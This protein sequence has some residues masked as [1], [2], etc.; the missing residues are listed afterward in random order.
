[1]QERSNIEAI[2]KEIADEKKTSP[3]KEASSELEFEIGKAPSEETPKPK[4]AP[5]PQK[6]EAPKEEKKTESE[7]ELEL[8][9]IFDIAEA[10]DSKTV[11]DDIFKVNTVYIPRFTGVSDHFYRYGFIPENEPATE[12][13]VKHEVPSAEEPIDAT[14]ELDGDI[15][16]EAKL[17]DV[18]E[19]KDLIDESVS[20]VFKFEDDTH[21]PSEPRREEKPVPEP[22]VTPEPQAEELREEAEIPAA[23]EESSEPAAISI[24]EPL[25]KQLPEK[26]VPRNV[27]KVEKFVSIGD[28]IAEETKR[29]YSAE[30]KRDSFKD[31]FLDSL[32]SKKLRFFVALAISLAVLVFESLGAFGVDLI[33]LFNFEAKPHGLAVIDLECVSCIVLFAFP[34]IV[35]ALKRAFNKS[36][37]SDL[38]IIPAYF[39]YLIYSI[40]IMVKAPSSYPLFGA[41]IA[42]YSLSLIAS[43]YFKASAD[44]T[45]F[46]RISR[47]EDKFVVDNKFTRTLEKENMELDGLVEEYKSRTA[48]VFRTSFVADFFRRASFESETLFHVLL[49]LSASL[50]ASVLTAF[51]TYF[52]YDGILSAVTS[53]ALVFLFALPVF[54][55]FVH[56]LPHLHA[57]L[58][59]EEDNGTLI[60][61]SSYFDY[62]GV[63]VIC[64]NDTDVFDSE[65]VNIQRIMLYG[66]KENLTKALHQMS[67]LFMNVGGPLDAIFQES[68]DRKCAPANGVTVTES[69]IIGEIDGNKV[70]AGS[71]DFMR[72]EGVIVPPDD[73]G[74]RKSFDATKIM[75]AAENGVVYAKFYIRYRFSEEFTM[76][77]P[78]FK[79]E[80][81]IPLV[82]TRDP[83]LSNELMKTLTAGMGT[84]RI[85]KK[86]TTPMKDFAPS[87]I[88]AGMVFDGDRSNL[89]NLILLSKRYVKFNSHM[90]AL[91]RYSM[92][93]GLVLG[94]VL[95]LCGMASVIP[96]FV[97][98]LWQGAWCA[99]LTVLSRKFFKVHKKKKENK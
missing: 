84:I 68:L 79:E 50:G 93:A 32:M 39:V 98:L 87:K 95:S 85:L 61:E 60:G 41:L 57:T 6:Q 56:K 12:E 81:I 27:S 22:T 51:I 55:L 64:I 31:G 65:D 72:S 74:A 62:S 77:M 24:E 83:N 67:A 76:L 35:R 97:P 78:I 46:K 17:V 7:V 1:M 28:E 11:S 23:K 58:K 48:R 9:N 33:D 3:E 53:F 29:E 14:A 92:I 16:Y 25:A 15:S 19:G 4:L 5:A 38:F 88:S 10:E 59:A 96:V 37:S 70:M 42:A 20:T 8:P 86:N 73:D 45:S 40:V 69:G 82:Y 80:K 91:E 13:D 54:S 90:K 99:V 36:F 71:Y 26:Y 94:V 47:E 49:L 75:Y 2:L 21:V 34:E 30:V 63:D 52:I 18:T 89:L 43:S 44:F 66:N